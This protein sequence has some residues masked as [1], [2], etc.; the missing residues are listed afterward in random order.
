MDNMRLAKIVLGTELCD[1]TEV[2]IVLG[3]SELF[4][5]KLDDRIIRELVLFFRRRSQEEQKPE[6]GGG[7]DPSKALK[8]KQIKN[9]SYEMVR[10]AVLSADEVEELI[11][12]FSGESHRAMSILLIDKKNEPYL[13]APTDNTGEKL[14]RSLPL[15]FQKREIGDVLESVVIGGKCFRL[16][17]FRAKGCNGHHNNFQ[18]WEVK[19][20]L[21]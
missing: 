5:G 11:G 16:V 2:K 9:R 6:V 4:G 7:V 12:K 19:P 1:L 14:E 18:L 3:A 8:L 21:K 13:E 15:W 10:P 17:G 20:K